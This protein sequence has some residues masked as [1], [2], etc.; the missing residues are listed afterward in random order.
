MTSDLARRRSL[1]TATLGFA[2]LDTRGKPA[3]PEVQTVRKWLDNW[4]GRRRRRYRD[5]PAGLHAAPVERGRVDVAGDVLECTDAQLGRV[6]DRG[7]AMAGS[8]GRGVGGVGEKVGRTA[9]ADGA[10]PTV[11]LSAFTQLPCGRRD[12][13][14]ATS[15]WAFLARVLSIVACSVARRLPLTN[16][17]AVRSTRT[18]P[19]AEKRRMSM[20]RDTLKGQWTQ[21][22]GKARE[23]WGKLTD[24]E[25][26]QM[27]GNAEMLIGK[28]QERYG[29][30]REEAEREFD[31][32]Y[33]QHNRAA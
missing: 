32:W 26:D 24:D 17:V 10:N 16:D 4:A 31:R 22:K 33:E 14:S 20:N 1:L 9:G 25:L 27:Q 19:P 18:R 28:I 8:A 2:S 13:D 12:S 5:E 29:R 3:P 7:D 6:Q 23:Q 21:L 30:S 15:L 11:T